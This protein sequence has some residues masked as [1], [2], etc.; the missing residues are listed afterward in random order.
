MFAF[1]PRFA[2]SESL[3]NIGFLA[4]FAAL[5]AASYLYFKISANKAEQNI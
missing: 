5:S 4:A 1:T 2:Y 3:Q